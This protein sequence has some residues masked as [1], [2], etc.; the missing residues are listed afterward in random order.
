MNE[1]R[2]IN[3]EK[4]KLNHKKLNNK[5]IKRNTQSNLNFKINERN[6]GIDLVR[7][8][9]MF[10]I[11]IDHIIVHGKLREKYNND[12]ILNLI[13]IFCFWHVNSFGLISGIVG[14]KQYKYSNLLHLWFCV[15]FYSLSIYLFFKL[16]IPS[17][18]NDYNIISLFFPVIYRKYWYFTDYIGMYLFIPIINNGILILDKSELKF[19]IISL[20][21][22]FIILKDI[23]NLQLDSFLMNSGNSL[24]WIL[25]LYI[26]G[27]YIGKY[28]IIEKSDKKLNFYLI[29]VIVFISATL[30][31]FYLSLYQIPFINIINNLFIRRINSF[32]M[33]LQVI[34]LS[35]FIFHLKFNKIENKIISIFGPLTFGVYLIHDNELIRTHIISKIF[36]KYSNNLDI[37]SIIIIIFCKGIIIFFSC[38]IIEYIRYNL[39]KFLKI[40]KICI[41]IENFIVNI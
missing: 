4:A 11:V 38:I 18:V 27:A 13:L 7:I 5:E 33:I 14:Y 40:R 9:G 2:Q 35:L 30:L 12:K 21:T 10:S 37:S 34:S 36:E 41:L 16:F 17:Y 29:N 31:C 20:I 26:I 3:S 19:V 8:L 1:E 6:P 28:S 39:F 32:P 22:I 15:L 24:L 25:V 23:I